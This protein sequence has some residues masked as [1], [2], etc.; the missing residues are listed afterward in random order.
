MIIAYIIIIGIPCLLNYFIIRKMIKARR[1][2]QK[3]I[4][5][6]AIVTKTALRKYSKSSMDDVTF[7]YR[8]LTGK[9]YY[10]KANTAPG[11][12]TIGDH[13]DIKYLHEDPSQYSF[14]WGKGYLFLL[15]FC[16]ILL[17]FM[18]YASFKLSEIASIQ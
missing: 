8:D 2:Q 7:I 17:A 15:V 1:I 10:A 9:A 12:Y 3:G 11:K 14:D 13:V 5:T 16:L 6:H 4:A 18:I